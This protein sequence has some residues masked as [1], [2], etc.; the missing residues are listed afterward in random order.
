MF[1]DTSDTQLFNNN[2]PLHQDSLTL[3]DIRKSKDTII[4]F[5]GLQVLNFWASWCKPCLEEIPSLEE[6]QSNY[7]GINV[8]LLS[9]DDTTNLK[10]AIQKYKVNL[11]A[12][13]I[14]DTSIFKVPKILPRTVVLRN[15]TV[16]RDM[17][18]SRDWMSKEMRLMFDS[19]SKN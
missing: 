7:H 11:P 2:T 1:K 4:R 19:L 3:F 16:V 8:F 12:Y 9:F 17:Y 18:V 13:F 6:L 15:D 5:R 14:T 10:K